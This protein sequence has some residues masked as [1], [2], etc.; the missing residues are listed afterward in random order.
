MERTPYNTHSSRCSHLCF[1][2]KKISDE[3]GQKRRKK[4]IMCSINSQT[5]IK[6]RNVNKAY[7]LLSKAL[8]NLASSKKDWKE[9]L[10]KE[11][12]QWQSKTYLQQHM[13]HRNC[14]ATC[15]VFERDCKCGLLIKENGW[16]VVIHKM[17]G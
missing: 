1:L 14:G 3:R 12:Q 9:K 2:A 17:N 4:P 11:K 10:R 7:L 15:L 8:V 13:A 6:E 5:R 16:H